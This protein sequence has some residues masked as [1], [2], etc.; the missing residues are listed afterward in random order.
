[1]LDAEG[2]DRFLDLAFDR[3]FVGEQEV[4]GDLLGDGGSADRAAA[5]APVA[6]V[7]D[8]RARDA[9]GIDAGMGEEVLVLGREERL[10]HALGHGVDGH[11]D[12]LLGRVFGEQPPVARVDA[13]HHRRL[14]DREL[15]VIGQPPAEIVEAGHADRAAAEG[16]EEHQAEERGQGADHEHSALGA[17]AV[18]AV[19]T[20]VARSDARWA[21]AARKSGSNRRDFAPES[22]MDIG[23]RAARG[24]RAMKRATDSAGDKLTPGAHRTSTGQNRPNALIRLETPR[25]V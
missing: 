12:A 21:R 22:G 6:Q 10:D 14:V 13:G 17:K 16:D 5:L 24:K 4:L 25:F 9:G 3:D 11:E 2:E 8:Q 7:H 20:I 1:M 18:A 19:G 15:A 23:S